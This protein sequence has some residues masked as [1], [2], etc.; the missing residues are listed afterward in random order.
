LVIPLTVRALNGV[1]NRSIRG[2]V[3]QPA[4]PDF[5]LLVEALK[6]IQ[7]SRSFSLRVEKRGDEETAIAV[8]A[9]PRLLPEVQRDVE[10]VH[11]TLNLSPKEGEVVL[12]YGALQRSG[13]ELAVLSRSMLQ[14]ISH[15][16]ADVEVP[17][18]DVADG[19]TFANTETGS[20]PN[21]LDTP[22]VRIHSGATA[23]SDAFAAVRYKDS[24]Y[25]LDDSDFASKRGLTFLLLFFALAET[26]V[27]PQAPVLTIPIQ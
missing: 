7:L 2:G 14:I 21:P 12:T 9:A 27:V 23:P 24:W 13:N 11:R 4:D 6:R 20:D 18:E 5:Y 25:W 15:L 22:Q 3:R 16:A 1:Y 10:F 17:P 19:R 8:F 26:G